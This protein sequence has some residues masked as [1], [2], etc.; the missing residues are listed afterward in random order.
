M[1]F[2]NRCRNITVAHFKV[3]TFFFKFMNLCSWPNSLAG[4]RLWFYCKTANM[5][6]TPERNSDYI[7]EEPNPVAAL[8]EKRMCATGNKNCK[9]RKRD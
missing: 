9:F 8:L 4:R 2:F 5:T 7:H 3:Q 1:N 6:V